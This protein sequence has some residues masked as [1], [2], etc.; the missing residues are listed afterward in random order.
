[1]NCLLSASLSLFIVDMGIIVVIFL[2]IGISIGIVV[3]RGIET[4]KFQIFEKIN[5]E[6]E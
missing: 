3:A 2:I 4:K 6:Y 5:H 1:M